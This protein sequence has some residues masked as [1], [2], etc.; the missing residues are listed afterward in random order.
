SYFGARFQHDRT[1]PYDG[2]LA[3]PLGNAVSPGRVRSDPKR[4]PAW[5]LV[6][7]GRLDVRTGNFDE[8]TGGSISAVASAVA[9][10]LAERNKYADQSA[11][12]VRLCRYRLGYLLAVVRCYLH[13]SAGLRVPLSLAAQYRSVFGAV[14]SSSAHLVL[15]ADSACGTF[16]S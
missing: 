14:R 15:R 1:I 6:V 9:I 5:R 3:L 13:S 12:C 7:S 10:L 11:G 4:E 8:G 16:S 2:R